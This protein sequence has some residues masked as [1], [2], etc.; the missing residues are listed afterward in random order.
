MS[1]TDHLIDDIIGVFSSPKETL[2]RLASGRKLWT[3]FAIFAVIRILNSFLQPFN[4]SAQDLELVQDLGLSVDLL[5]ILPSLMRIWSILLIPV[6]F[7]IAIG[8]WHV[9]AMIMG[10]EMPLSRFA[11][12]YGFTFFPILLTGP[13]ALLN[14]I[15]PSLLI[16]FLSLVLSIWVL[17]LQVLAFRIAYNINWLKSIAGF[18]LPHITAF[19]LFFIGLV[20]SVIFLGINLV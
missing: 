10:S 18:F 15:L 20:I 12:A 3:G 8:I 9:A 7:A 6:T 4:P 19:I 16:A 5:T 17:I 11:A 13:L 2:Q 1:F 14:G